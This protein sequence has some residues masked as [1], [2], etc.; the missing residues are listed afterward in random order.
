MIRGSDSGIAHNYKLPLVFIEGS[1][2]NGAF[3][4]F[5]YVEQVLEAHMEDIMSA[6]R[7]A[8]VEPILME[9]GNAAHGIKT[10]R[11][12]AA[13]WKQAHGIILF[14]W[15]SNSPDLNPIEQIWRIIK[16]NLCK[17]RHEIHS[18][19]ELKAAICEEWDRIPLAKINELISSM[20]D[21]ATTVYQNW[22]HATG[23]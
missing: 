11:N 22:G 13:R 7:T 6:M 4:Q 18:L 20:H 17:R 5:D 3:L 21:R 2:K 9:D 14:D 23:F 19:S 15:A 8:G 12:S 10:S 16:Q 1:G